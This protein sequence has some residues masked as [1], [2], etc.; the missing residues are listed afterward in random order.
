MQDERFMERA[1]E[2]A[3][4]PAFASPNPRVGAV[5]VRDGV[6]VGEGAHR[7]P[8]S[9]HAEVTALE[10]IDARGTTVYV[11]LEPCNHRGR[12]P[13]CAPVLVEAGVARVVAAT[14][15]PDP[16]VAGTGFEVLRN[17]GIEV[18]AG[19]LREEAERLNR[20]YLHH[21]RTGRSFVSLKLALTLDGRMT[22]PDGSSQWI[23]GAEARRIV[24]ARRLECDAVMVG[25]GT[26][27]ADDPKL[28]VRDVPAARQP[29]R[30]VVDA[31]GR[32]PA[33]AAA[34]G[35]RSIVATTAAAPHDVQ[36]AWKET[37]AEVLVLPEGPGGVDLTAL[38]DALGAREIVEVL[39]EGGPRLASS[40]IRA[41][42]AGRL[43][44]HYGP[45]LSG[46]GLTIADL[47]V[48]SMADGLRFEIEETARAG[49]DLI[50]TLAG[51]L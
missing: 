29:V 6:V 14:E 33:E 45:V 17:A 19:V 10:G 3:R 47:G 7:G 13:P 1:L 51:A 11:T 35:E 25:A 30:V 23:T 49:D 42:L 34:L 32:V 26:A 43:E 15:D 5:V 44:L 36:I 41:G 4:V 31:V 12:T 39:C 40:L 48:R 38:V 16:R 22:A 21:R 2:L 28:T 50:V 20:A 46:G 18:E 37:G 24:H 8:G 9:A 27:L